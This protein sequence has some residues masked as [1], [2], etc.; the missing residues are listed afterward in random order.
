MSSSRDQSDSGIFDSLC[1]NGHQTPTYKH[2][3]KV[4]YVWQ[5]F[6]SNHHPTIFIVLRVWVRFQAPPLSFLYCFFFLSPPILS[7]TFFFLSFYFSFSLLSL[8]Y[9]SHTTKPMLVPASL[10]PAIGIIRESKEGVGKKVPTFF[11]NNI[12]MCT[13]YNER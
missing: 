7:L 11:W 9:E 5:K 4:R 6:E 1:I 8:I 3:C 10:S 2:R 12:I 13:Y